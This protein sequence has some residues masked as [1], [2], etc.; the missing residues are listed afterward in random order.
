MF[1]I[2]YNDRFKYWNFLFLFIDIF[3]KFIIYNDD[4]GRIYKF[5]I[6]YN[7]RILEVFLGYNYGIT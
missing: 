6:R 7:D 5:Y 3:M 1:Y 2:Y 4:Y